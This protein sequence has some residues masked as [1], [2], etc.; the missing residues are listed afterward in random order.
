MNAKDIAWF[1]GVLGDITDV[2]A[3]IATQKEDLENIADPDGRGSLDFGE[4]G[5]FFDKAHDLIIRA[6]K[7]ARIMK[8]ITAEDL[9]K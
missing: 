4:A 5:T 8:P 7:A 9:D 1:K 3:D 6:E 2:M